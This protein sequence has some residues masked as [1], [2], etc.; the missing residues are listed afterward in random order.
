METSVG[1]KETK[2]VDGHRKNETEYGGDVTQEA[3]TFRLSAADNKNAFASIGAQVHRPIPARG[4][5]YG[6]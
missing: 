4:G 6:V 1:K 2:G 3:P 5:C